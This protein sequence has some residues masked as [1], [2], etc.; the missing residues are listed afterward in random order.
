M[1]ENG[2]AAGSPLR[3]ESFV[4]DAIVEIAIHEIGDDFDGALDVEILESFL[5]KIVRDGGD[6][7][8]LLDGKFGNGKIAAVAADEGDVRAVKGSDEGKAARSGHG[9]R[10]QGADGMRNRVVDVEQ[11]ERLGF[12]NFEHFCGK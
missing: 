9:T 8:A 4:V 11:V 2:F 7:V 3:A 5:Q 10:E 12:E 1:H 6:A